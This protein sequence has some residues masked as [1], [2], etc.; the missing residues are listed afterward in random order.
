MDKQPLRAIIYGRCSTS[1]SKQDVEVQLQEL[2][3]YC[4]AYGWQ[5][6][7]VWEYGSG[8]KSDNQPKL[9]GVLEHIRLKRYNVLIVFSMDRFSRQSPSKINALLDVIVEQYG[10][11]FMALQQGIDSQNE[12]TWHVV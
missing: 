11:R 3:R 5:Y 1:E 9:E 7:E 12:L 4:D 8:Y 10:C 6:E 2:R